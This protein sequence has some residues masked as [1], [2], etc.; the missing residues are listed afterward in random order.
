MMMNIWASE[1]KEKQKK[2]ERKKTAANSFLWKPSQF[3]AGF[4]MNNAQ[5][6]P[7]SILL[8]QDDEKIRQ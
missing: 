4:M 1:T 6:N 3:L 8:I 2:K 7:S 5:W